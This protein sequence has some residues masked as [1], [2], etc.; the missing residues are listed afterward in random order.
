MTSRTREIRKGFVMRAST[1]AVDP[2]FVAAHGLGVSAMMRM[3]IVAG[4]SRGAVA[5]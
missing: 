4:S 1:P 2:L 5:A 3:A